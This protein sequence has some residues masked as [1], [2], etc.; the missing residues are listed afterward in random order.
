[1]SSPGNFWTEKIL[2]HVPRIIQHNFW[3]LLFSFIFAFLLFNFVHTNVQEETEYHMIT[4]NELNLWQFR[5]LLVD[6]YILVATTFCAF[7]VICIVVFY[8]K[9]LHIDR[10]MVIYFGKW[11]DTT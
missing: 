5:Y 9:T 1:M 3:R 6:T 7:A 4:I 8:R 10:R 11:H 2:P